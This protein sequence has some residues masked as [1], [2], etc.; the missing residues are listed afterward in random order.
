[1]KHWVVLQGTRI[2]CSG[3]NTWMLV[4]GV[5]SPIHKEWMRSKFDALRS[6]INPAP[7]NRIIE[8]KQWNSMVDFNRGFMNKKHF[9]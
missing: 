4:Q 7:D 3:V 6:A 2:L 5:V 1:M 9:V 8:Y